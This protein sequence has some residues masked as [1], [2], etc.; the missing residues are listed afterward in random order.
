MECICCAAA[1][2]ESMTVVRDGHF[3]PVYIFLRDIVFS[4]SEPYGR[5][6]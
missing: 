4:K 3:Y 1:F 2:P 6:W 5:V